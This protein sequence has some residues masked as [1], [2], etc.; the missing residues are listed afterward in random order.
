MKNLGKLALGAALIATSFTS[1]AAM[2]TNGD[3]QTCDLTGWGTDSFTFGS[4]GYATDFNAVDT[5]AG[6]CAAEIGIDLATTQEFIGNSLF[7][8][9]DLSVAGGF[10]INLSFDWAFDGE[11]TNVNI[12]RDFINIGL[13]KVNNIGEYL[14]HD[15][16]GAVG[17]LVSTDQYGSGSVS[18]DL[19]ASLFNQSDWFIDFQINAGNVNFLGS[20][21]TVDNVALTT[22]ALPAN[23]VPEPAGL[24]LIGLSALAFGRIARKN[25]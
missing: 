12:G 22:F 23:P 4:P 1:Q 18:V 21:L 11:E 10:G 6:N 24:A 15:E 13:G 2:I 3:F 14:L 8:E 19:D 20:L 7:Q 17:N 5:G 25:A 16:N 9:M